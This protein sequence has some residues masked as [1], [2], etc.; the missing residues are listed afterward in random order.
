MSYIQVDSHPCRQICEWRGRKGVCINRREP[1]NRGSTAHTLE[2]CPSPMCVILPNPVVLGQTVQEFLRRSTWKI[3][4]LMSRLSRSLKV[5]GTDTDQ[6]AT[7]NFP[8]TYHSN[9]GPISYH[10]RDKWRFQSK[11]AIFPTPVYLTPPLKWPPLE[12]G[13]GAWGQ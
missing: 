10:F 5:I 13:T 7:Y 3:W 12:L 2:M 1:P 4:P 11:I 9:H 6:S 8:L